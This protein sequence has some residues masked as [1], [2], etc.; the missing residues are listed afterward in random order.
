MLGIQDSATIMAHIYFSPAKC[1]RAATKDKPESNRNP[2]KI[3][4][5]TDLGGLGS[6]ILPLMILKSFPFPGALS[7]SRWEGRFSGP[8]VA[9]GWAPLPLLGFLSVLC[10]H[11]W[12]SHSP[13]ATGTLWAGIPQHYPP[14]KHL[15]LGFNSA[16]AM[17]LALETTKR[18]WQPS[19]APFA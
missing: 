19:C 5:H 1:S 6:Q 3:S 14:P 7:L 9:S 15:I 17:L 11:Q 8:W 12:S 18:P 4:I 2:L 13:A 10:W 16:I